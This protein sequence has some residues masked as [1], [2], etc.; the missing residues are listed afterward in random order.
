[1]LAKMAIM[2]TI[3]TADLKKA[4]AFYTDTLGFEKVRT[5]PDGGTVFA[6]GQGSHFLV[7]PTQFAGT[8]EH[9]LASF[10]VDDIQAEAKELRAKGVKFEDYD[11]GEL[12]TVDGIA[13][14]GE[15]KAAWFKDPDGNIIALTQMPR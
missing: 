5:T 7:Y 12:K 10:L 1:M 2:P 8:A 14:M 11:F 6:C 9:T 13:D 3:P 15:A 4:L